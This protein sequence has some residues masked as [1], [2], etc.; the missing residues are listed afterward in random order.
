MPELVWTARFEADVQL[1]FERLETSLEG[2]GEKFYGD[3]LADLRQ[4][5][6]Q[7]WSGS[8][9]RDSTLRRLLVLGLRYGVIYRVETRGIILHAIFDQRQDPAQIARLI[10]QI[11]Q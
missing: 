4:L 11:E 1:L 7:P 8:R 9:L 3:L 10:R 5:E 6:Q 2:A